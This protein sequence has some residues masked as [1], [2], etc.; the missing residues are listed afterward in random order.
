M[1]LCNYFREKIIDSF[2]KA[3]SII[4]PLLPVLLEVSQNFIKSDL[5]NTITSILN[6]LR[7]FTFFIRNLT[8][9]RIL[10]CIIRT[11]YIL[12]NPGNTIRKADFF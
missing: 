10:E 7:M 9:L 4:S 12:Y 5:F 6:S 11:F 2:L 8:L 3:Q 1:L